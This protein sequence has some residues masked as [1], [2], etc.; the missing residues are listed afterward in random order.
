MI[1][2]M[3]HRAE[4]ISRG[5]L[6]F[7]VKPLAIA[8]FFD[9]LA[10][11]W[12][13][14]LQHIVAYPFVFLFFGAIM[15][16][17]W[18]GGYIAGF[19]AVALSSALVAFFF[20]PPLYSFNIGEGFRGFETAFVVCAIAVTAVSAARKRA[21]LAIRSARDELEARL[22]ER[23]A[24]LE[25]NSSELMLAQ[26]RLARLSRT[27]S[28]AEMAA[29]IAHELNQPLT[30]L[31][32]DAN[33]CRR[34]LQH[35]PAK[36]DRAASAAERIVRDTRKATEVV[37]RVRALFT[38]TQYRREPTD[39]NSLVEDLIRLLQNEAAG[40]GISIRVNLD[41][42]LRPI[43]IDAVQVRQVLLN[44][45]MNGMD[46]MGGAHDRRQL[47]VST[48]EVSQEEVLVTVRNTGPALTDEVNARMFEPFFTTKHDGLGMGLAICR[49][50]IEEHEGRIWAEPLDRGVAFHF[51]LKTSRT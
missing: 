3:S 32:A 4:V 39:L 29:A 18:F 22:Q 20:V 11:L 34:W 6:K 33:A 7:A 16:S 9:L 37:N 30:A 45:V 28:M 10:L 51:T 12:T 17:A 36:V 44:L 14:L 47:E 42:N 40:R 31:V 2:N 1:L 21:E 48:T 26:E 46:A 35:Q 5:A 25:R 13:F 41:P 8:L 49:S 27:L 50:I 23:T 43:R 15:G 24:E 38:R 19:I